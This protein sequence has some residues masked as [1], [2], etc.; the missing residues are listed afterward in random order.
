MHLFLK[1]L[2]VMG[3]GHRRTLLCGRSV[4]VLEPLLKEKVFRIS[5]RAI[6]IKDENCEMNLFVYQRSYDTVCMRKRKFMDSWLI[7]L[8]RSGSFGCSEI[9]TQFVRD[10]FG[11]IFKRHDFS[12][13]VRSFGHIFTSDQL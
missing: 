6:I 11:K 1:K 3:N 7:K 12:E 4:R 10:S 5:T 9:L 8:V 13:F 2:I